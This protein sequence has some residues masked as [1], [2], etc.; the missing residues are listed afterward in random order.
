MLSYIA[1]R[2][3]QTIPTSL[4]VTFIVFFLMNMVGDPARLLLPEDASEEDIAALRVTLELDKPVLYRYGKY[5]YRLTLGDTG[6]SF[7]YNEPA[8]ALV[9]ERLPVTLKLAG[10]SL[11]LG[12][13]MAV[14][15][16][17][18]SAVRRN[19]LIDLLATGTAV[20][21][22]SMPNFWLGIM[23]MMLVAVQWRLL[24][25]SGAATWKHFIL[26]TL[27]IGTGLA[28]SLT[29]LMRSSML[30]VI[31]QDYVRTARSKG[32]TERI[33]IFKHGLRNALIPVLTVLGLQMALLIDGAFITEQVFAI[34]GMGQLGVRSLQTLDFAVVQTVVLLGAM[35]T[36]TS[37][38]AVD[39][40]YT[41]IDP[42]IR[43]Q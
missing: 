16:G 3:L 11:G 9:L 24:P 19:S 29:R 27:T 42:R 23:L 8:A 36:V 21:G 31:G 22:R 13:L 41:V 17:V 20:L 39:L 43:Y 10:A 5:L 12:L 38:L 15:L 18:L 4:I 30:E 34:P 2:M 25:V 32:L 35:L 6:T 40:L 37:S 33:V 26:P 1:N 28:A 14:P 7:R